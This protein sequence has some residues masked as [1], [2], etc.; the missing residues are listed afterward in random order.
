MDLRVLQH[1]MR[2][3]FLAG[4]LWFALVLE[5]LGRFRCGSL[6]EW[7]KPIW[8]QTRHARHPAVAI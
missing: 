2:G 4:L 6:L 1:G 8:T 3:A 7:G 5:K